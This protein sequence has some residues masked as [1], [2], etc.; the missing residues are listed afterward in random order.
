MTDQ[1]IVLDR[2]DGRWYVS[3]VSTT[4]HGWLDMLREIDS[5]AELF[6]PLLMPFGPGMSPF[7]TGG[8][9]SFPTETTVVV[10]DSTP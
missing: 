5:L 10:P 2:V 4:T 9:E 7:D 6:G 8:D 1:V 3:P